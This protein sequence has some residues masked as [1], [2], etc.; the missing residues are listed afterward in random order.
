MLLP[1][2]REVVFLNVAFVA[3]ALWVCRV[4]QMVPVAWPRGVGQLGCHCQ[5]HLTSALGLGCR[6]LCR[7]VALWR[8]VPCKSPFGN[9]TVGP[10]DVVVGP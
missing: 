7:F 5:G 8:Y 4:G 10:D 1:V 6:S 9:T 3:C 2:H